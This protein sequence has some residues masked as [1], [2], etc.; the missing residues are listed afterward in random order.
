MRWFRPGRT[1]LGLFD[2]D[3]KHASNR[4]AIPRTSARASLERDSP[5]FPG[6]QQQHF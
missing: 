1:S 3:A 5:V 2:A 6:G 4:F